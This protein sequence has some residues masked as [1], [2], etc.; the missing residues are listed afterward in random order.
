[1]NLAFDPYI[2]LGIAP[3]VSTEDIKAAYRRI[4]LRLHPDRNPNPGAAVQLQDINQAH[5]LLLD[6]AQRSAYDRTRHERINPAH[7]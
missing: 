1:M 3:D 6:P 4:A 7:P 2:L 5:T